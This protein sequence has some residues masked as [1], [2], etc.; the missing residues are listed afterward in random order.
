MFARIFL[1]QVFRKCA[2]T[3]GVITCVTQV[4]GSARYF[5]T[6]KFPDL[7]VLQLQLRH[8]LHVDLYS[9]RS[10]RR[11]IY[12]TLPLYETFNLLLICTSAIYFARR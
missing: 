10:E 3:A 5:S 2:C 8:L 9:I 7:Q 6:Q 1:A 11:Y 4:H 12:R